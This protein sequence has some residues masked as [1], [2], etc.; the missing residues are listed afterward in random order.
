M[1]NEIESILIIP[2]KYAGNTEDNHRI[3]DCYVGEGENGKPKVE[4]R[5]FEAYS[6]EGIENPTYL[7]VGIIQGSGYMQINFT[8]AKEF[9]DMFK[10]HWEVLTK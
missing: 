7:F 6:T 10:E 8:D 3:I 9:E 4:K 1:T 5:K 2:A